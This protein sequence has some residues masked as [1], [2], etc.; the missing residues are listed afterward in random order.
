M[1]LNTQGSS[2]FE[3]VLGLQKPNLLLVYNDVNCT[4]IIISSANRGLT[5]SAIIRYLNSLNSIFQAKCASCHNHLPF[6]EASYSRKP[7]FLGNFSS[8]HRQQHYWSIANEVQD[9][10]QLQLN[11]NICL[12]IS[13]SPA[14]HTRG[15]TK[16]NAKYCDW[17]LQQ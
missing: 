14:Y 17:C 2:R 6:N 8:T 16:S 10:S 4:Q 5:F 11:S 3:N 7:K 13:D 1:I 9:R 15:Q 12:P